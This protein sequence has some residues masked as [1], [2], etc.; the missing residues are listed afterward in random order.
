MTS[1]PALPGEPGAVPDVAALAKV[2]ARQRAEM[3]RLQDLAAASAVIERAKGVLMALTGCSPEAAHEM[4]LQRARN[5]GHSLMEECWITLGTLVPSPGPTADSPAPGAT[6]GSPAPGAEAGDGSPAR[7]HR[8]ATGTAGG[9]GASG[10]GGGRPAAGSGPST[11]S[12]PSAD[13]GPG[14]GADRDDKPAGDATGTAGTARRAESGTAA[15]KGTAAEAVAAEGRTGAGAGTVPVAEDGTATPADVTS[16][17]A[18][19]GA[20][21]E[22]TGSAGVGSAAGTGSATPADARGA[23]TGAEGAGT[24]TGPGGRADAGAGAGTGA[25]ADEGRAWAVTAALLEEED[26][27]AVLA[28]IGLGLA[29]VGTPDDLARCLHEHLAGPVGAAAVMVYRRLPAGG[30]ALMGHSGVGDTLAAQWRHVPP[31]SGV[32]ALDVLGS[33]QALWLEHHESD[34]KRYLLI[35]DATGRWPS[36]AWLPVLS[37]G[38]ADVAIGVLRERRGA[39]TPRERELLQAVARL[40]AGRMRAFLARGERFE[41]GADDERVHALFAAMPG[42][43][44]LL[45]PLRSP[46]G[47]VEDYRVDAATAATV[48]VVGRSG[49]ELVG[50]RVLECWPA[51]A[52]EP[53]WQGWLRTLTTGEPYES[54]PYAQQELSSGGRELSTYSVRAARMG[55]CLVVTWLRQDSSDRQEQRLADLQR[56]GRLGWATWNLRTREAAWSSHVYAL[57]DRDPAHGPLRLEELADLAVPEDAPALAEAAR[58]LVTEGKPFDVPFRVRTGAG[59]RH[60]RLVAETVADRRG[61]PAE[62]LGFVQDLTAQRSAELALVESERAMLAQHGVLRAERML[63]GRLQHALLPLPRRAVRLAGLRVDLAYLPAQVGI[64]VGGD[65][66]SAI[67]LADGDALFVVGDVAGHG[68]D[69][70]ATMAQLRFTAKGMIITGSSLTG[71]LSRLNTLLLHSGENHRTATMV[72]ARYKRAEHLLVWAQAGHPPPLLL[73]RGEPRYLERPHGVLLGAARA[74]VYEE[75]QVRLE[76]GDR[77]L[78]YTDGLVERPGEIIE[79]GLDR[80]AAAAAAHGT[81]AAGSLTPLLSAVLEGDRRD[82]VCVLDVRVPHDP[83]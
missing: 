5:A 25:A 28:V 37:G 56:L 36:R 51:V 65:W 61:S 46:S 20:P 38:S 16:T 44:T 24:G 40:C 31:L 71:A 66:F 60:L 68:I 48:D 59:T 64:N 9:E 50:L 57:L 72:L 79:R 2:V 23:G 73:R 43:T 34:S 35:G 8:T 45:T 17:A 82:D 6:T 14:A 63:A 67:E 83:S 39:F 58:E 10:T 49:R 62:I 19:T 27:S 75:G 74:P 80:L 18:R 7:S 13:A 42:A 32:A 76:P 4:L 12:G 47:Q 70:V 55:D 11:G 1:E 21:A 22:G 3:D 52:E 33:G 41:G 30:M 26:E 53:V 15:G 29:R 69:A 54:E 81:D 78:L 77:L